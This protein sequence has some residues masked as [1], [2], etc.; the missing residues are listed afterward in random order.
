MNREGHPAYIAV[1]DIYMNILSTSR[2]SGT[3]TDKHRDVTCDESRLLNNILCFLLRP[4][5]DESKGVHVST[6]HMYMADV[7]VTFALFVFA[8][9]CGLSV[10]ESLESVPG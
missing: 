9:D 4:R 7:N 5:E 2:P 3:W 10:N 6:R 8:P 1:R